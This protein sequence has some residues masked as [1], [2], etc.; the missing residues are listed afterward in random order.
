MI[1]EIASQLE[2]NAFFNE[3][4]SP[5]FLHSWEW[6]EFQE[7]LGYGV[8]R[9]AITDDSVIPRTCLLAGRARNQA[10]NNIVAICQIIKIKA[11]RKHDLYSTRPIFKFPY[12]PQGKQISNFK[13]PLS[14]LLAYLKNIAR[15]KVIPLSA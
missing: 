14:E 6:G 12:V 7:K 11:K 1:T 15:K 9:L 4:G 10:T 5:S 2:W 3:A 8:L 13:F